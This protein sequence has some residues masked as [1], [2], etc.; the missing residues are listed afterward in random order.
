MVIQCNIE[1][2][3]RKVFYTFRLSGKYFLD[4]LNIADPM[5]DIELTQALLIISLHSPDLFR[6]EVQPCQ[7]PSGSLKTRGV[8]V[9]SQTKTSAM[10]WRLWDLNAS[11]C[12]SFEHLWPPSPSRWRLR[13]T[14][15]GWVQIL[16]D[17]GSIA[18]KSINSYCFWV[19][20]TSIYQLFCCWPGYQGVQGYD[21]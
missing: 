19:W 15:T 1:A 8:R 18:I 11:V 2:P 14:V 5:L 9:G 20:W 7:R 3:W 17:Y 21:P 4:R 16:Y 6:S 12:R 10:R 13:C